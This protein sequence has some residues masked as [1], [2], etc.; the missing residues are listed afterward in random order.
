MSLIFTI[1]DMSISP[2]FPEGMRGEDVMAC[3]AIAEEGITNAV[4]RG[5]A[6]AVT[7]T[8]GEDHDHWVISVIDNGVGPRNGAPGCS[9]LLP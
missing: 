4:R 1:V 3:V 5:L 6:S 9:G 7:I 2:G 8:L